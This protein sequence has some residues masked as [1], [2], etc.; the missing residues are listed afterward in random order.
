MVRNMYFYVL[1]LFLNILADL[2]TLVPQAMLRASQMNVFPLAIKSGFT[3]FFTL[4]LA[5]HW[6]FL[7]KNIALM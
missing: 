1:F 2:S 4:N 7:N 3:V 6:T 5:W